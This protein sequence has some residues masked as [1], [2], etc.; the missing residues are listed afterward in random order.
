MEMDAR[1]SVGRVELEDLP[2]LAAPAEDAFE[3]TPARRDN[4]AFSNLA[5]RQAGSG[6]PNSSRAR[7]KGGDHAAS[8]GSSRGNR[9]CTRRRTDGHGGQAPEDPDPD[10]A[11][12]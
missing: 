8:P 2:I 12:D 1:E 3:R 6:R 7:E 5:V 10:R 4:R 9:A 11:V